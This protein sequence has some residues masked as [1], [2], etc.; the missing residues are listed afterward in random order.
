LVSA[1]VAEGG[2]PVV[3]GIATFVRFVVRRGEMFGRPCG[4]GSDSGGFV[5][6]IWRKLTKTAVLNHRTDE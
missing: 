4:F 2:S 1:V 3:I 5:K 6:I